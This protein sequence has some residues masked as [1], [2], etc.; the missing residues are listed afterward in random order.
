MRNDERA[1]LAA[2]QFNWAVTPDDIWSPAEH[3][4]EGLHA[5]VIRTVMASVAAA[6]GSTGAS[7]IGIALEGEKGSARPTCW[8]G[9]GSGCRTAVGTSS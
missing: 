6:R 4:V 5:N 9:S 2:V 7:P 1:A 3:H 8:G